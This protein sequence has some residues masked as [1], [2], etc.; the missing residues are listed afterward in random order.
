MAPTQNGPTPAGGDRSVATFYDAAGRRVH[1]PA[2][3][4]T[5]EIAE[6]TRHGDE[7]QRT[8]MSRGEASANPYPDPGTQMQDGQFAE[9]VKG[10]W[11]VWNNVDGMFTLATTK[12]ALLNALG[13]AEAPQEAQRHLL[14]NIMMLPSWDAAPRG[15]KDEVGRWLEATRPN[16]ATPPAAPQG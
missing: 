16:G 12:D 9:D 10:T 11:D 13:F 3:A 5:V 8:Y 2:D 4:D 6:R 14:G 7:I 15:L 1:R